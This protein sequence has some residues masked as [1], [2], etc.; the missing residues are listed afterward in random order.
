MAAR[1]TPSQRFLPVV[2]FCALDSTSMT[3][4]SSFAPTTGTSADC[5]VVAVGERNR[6]VVVVVRSDPQ[7]CKKTWPHRREKD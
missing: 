2:L 7:K 5:H 4:T 6:L 1:T 3:T